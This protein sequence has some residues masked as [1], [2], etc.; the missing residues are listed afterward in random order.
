MSWLALLRELVKMSNSHD[1]FDKLNEE[2]EQEIER[3]EVDE[4]GDVVREFVTAYRN[5]E[6]RV[7]MTLD[8]RGHPMPSIPNGSFDLEIDYIGSPSL[9]D[10]QDA[11][12]LLA[13][14][15]VK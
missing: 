4:G 2:A 11:L 3:Y 7:T 10:L 5:I 14:M 13:R 15:G 1:P 12:S 8:V 6:Q 9:E